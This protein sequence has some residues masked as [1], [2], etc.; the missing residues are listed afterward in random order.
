MVEHNAPSSADAPGSSSDDGS[1]PADDLID[2]LTVEFSAHSSTLTLTGPESSFRWIAPEVLA[3][4]NLS[5]PSDIWALGW[6]CYEVSS[7]TSSYLSRR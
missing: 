6:I 4:D 7:P 1:G 2:P 5:L 3:E